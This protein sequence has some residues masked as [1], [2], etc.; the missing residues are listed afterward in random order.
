MKKF[1]IFIVIMMALTF[2][3]GESC[4]QKNVKKIGDST[5]PFDSTLVLSFFA[6][7]PALEK[8]HTNLVEIYRNNQYRHIWLDEKGIVEYGYSLNSKAK[9]MEEDGISATFP[10]QLVIDGVFTDGTKN[11]LNSTDTE[12][13]LSSLYLYYA[14]KMFGGIDKKSTTSIGWLLPRKKLSYT[15]MLDSFISDDEST[16]GDSLI[17]FSQYFKLRDALKQYRKIE[18]NGGWK[19]VEMNPWEKSFKPND[20]ARTILQVREFLF[21]TGDLF[22]NN[23]SESYDADLVAAVLRYQIRNG[24]K[25]DSLLLPVH[26]QHMNVP[27][28]ER[29]KS[30]VVNMERCRWL[31]HEI[32]LA[33]E[34]I[35]VNIPSYELKFIRDGKTEFQ[36][37]VVVGKIMTQTVIFAGKMSYLAFSPYWNLP[38]NIIEKE[39]KPGIE[40]DENY[41]KK[42]NMEWNNGQVRQLPGKYNSL[43]LVKFMFPNSN[44]IYLH[45][46]P[47]KKLFKEESRA[48]SHGCVR[49]DRARELAIKILENDENWTPEKIDVVMHAGEE[50]IYNLKQ[51]IP[52]YIGYFTTWV[53]DLGSIGFYEDV[54]ERDNRLALLLFY[55]E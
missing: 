26:I 45:D 54:Y 49:V 23:L 33:E 14:E 1:H 4:T 44:E 8:Y 39:V 37:N 48:F 38:K 16:N 40:K 18:E 27:V 30:I 7:Y 22:Q 36:S 55:K 32:F 11:K 10:Y 17:L 12:L 9:D 35:F 51:K 31:S 28:G 41:L 3:A 25:P 43:G 21:I 6:S 42:H 2:F 5:I 13:L 34:Y 29:I 46:T 15:D 20:T 52:V 24:F 19:P 47:S 50:S 53:D